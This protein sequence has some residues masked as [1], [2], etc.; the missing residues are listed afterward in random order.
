[1]TLLFEFWYKW[2]LKNKIVLNGRNDKNINV[3]QNPEKTLKYK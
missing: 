2:N 1:M 3:K